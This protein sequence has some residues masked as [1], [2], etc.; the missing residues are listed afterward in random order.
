MLKKTKRGAV[1]AVSYLVAAFAVVGGLAAQ[2]YVR[3]EQYKWT[4][5]LVYQHSFAELTTAMSEL[6]TALQK[7]VYASSPCMR[8][9]LLAQ[10]YG[11]AMTAQLAVA[12]LPYSFVELEQTA[13]FVAKVGDY[14]LALS[15]S[16]TLNRSITQEELAGLQSL[17]Q[18]SGGL[19]QTLNGLQAQIYDGS[20]RMDTVMTAQKLLSR[21]TE[22][23]NETESGS[24]F[25]DMEAD[26]PELPSLI[27]DGPFSQHLADKAPAALE[28]LEYADQQAAADAAAQFLELD[29]GSFSL[30]SAG[31]G[32]LPTWGF[33]AESQ[34]GELYVEVSQTGGKVVSLFTGSTVGDAVL[35]SEEAVAAA[36]DFLSKRGYDGMTDTYWMEEDGKLTINFA[37]EI[38]GV[39]IY[40]DLVKVTVALDDGDIVGLEAAGYLSNHKQR[41]LETPTVTPEQ[42]REKVSADLTV[43][44]QRMAL[45]PTAGEYE[46]LCME[47]KTETAD[48]RHV[49]IYVNALTG[50]EEK[51]L[52]LLEDERGTLVL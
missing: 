32:T 35:T 20:L 43:L 33:S 40:P 7:G 22:G 1:R 41:T 10:I 46:V 18:L 30:V 13:A 23:G 31:E 19:S 47:F 5:Q 3:A 45:I 27:Y 29:A 15:R 6:D 2:N 9:T 44:S 14:A 42:A 38:D 11:K 37:P 36:A 12:Q 21:D 50:E 52:L 28:G 24:A 39:L 51:I 34:D 25:Q 4:L 48:G 16:S 17:S 8:S 49:L 26:F